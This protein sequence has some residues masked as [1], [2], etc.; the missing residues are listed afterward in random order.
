MTT[1]GSKNL[2]EVLSGGT[3]QQVLRGID[4]PLLAVPA[5]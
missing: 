1:A 2:S 3:T 4:C 5:E